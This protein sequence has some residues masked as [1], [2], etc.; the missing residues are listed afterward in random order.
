MIT[1]LF[2]FETTDNAGRFAAAVLSG[3]FDVCTSGI[4]VQVRCSE[5][6]WNVVQALAWWFG[7]CEQHRSQNG[8]ERSF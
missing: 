3:G 5:K 4:H 1:M 6:I 2:E 8:C 7:G